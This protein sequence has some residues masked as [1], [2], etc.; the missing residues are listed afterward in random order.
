MMSEVV[1]A[2][3][4]AHDVPIWELADIGTHT[5]SRM[6]HRLQG[7]AGPSGTHFV[8]LTLHA[9]QTEL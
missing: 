3:F 2:F 4:V 8:L 6:S 9:A 1:S 5:S 7:L